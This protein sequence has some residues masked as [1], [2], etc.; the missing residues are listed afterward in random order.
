MK[1]IQLFEAFIESI[2][3]V[4]IQP[5]LVHA[6]IKKVTGKDIVDYE[7][8]LDSFKYQ[9]VGSSKWHSISRKE[10]EKAIHKKESVNEA[11]DKVF[12]EFSDS[13]LAEIEKEWEKGSA[14]K[15]VNMIAKKL[16]GVDVYKLDLDK[17]SEAELDTLYN[18]Y[19]SGGRKKAA[20][21]LIAIYKLIK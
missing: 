12:S 11:N 8:Q 7:E 20:T 13:D 9:L 4:E 15:A 14:I 6:G 19:L 16:H 17:K 21:T 2:K 18:D 10:L 1:Y 3:P 5:A